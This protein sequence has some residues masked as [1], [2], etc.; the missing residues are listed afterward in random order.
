MVPFCNNHLQDSKRQRGQK[1]SSLDLRGSSGFKFCSNHFFCALVFH[2]V[3]H[4]IKWPM[5]YAVFLGSGC[6]H[7]SGFLERR[8]L[9]EKELLSIDMTAGREEACQSIVA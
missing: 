2:S 8:S 4:F 7:R 3:K 5:A 6:V 9:I 1:V